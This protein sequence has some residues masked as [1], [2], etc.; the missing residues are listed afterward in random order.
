M[1]A[2]SKRRRSGAQ[3]QKGERKVEDI[4]KSARTVLTEDGY[5]GFTMRKIASTAGMAIGNLHY[6]YKNKDDI[7]HDLLDNTIKVYETTFDHIL[8]DGIKTDAEKF[9]EIISRIVVD[10]GTKQ[11]TRFFPE[12]WA[13]AN[14]DDCVAQGMAQLYQRARKYMRVLI[15]NLNPQ[16]NEDQCR[17]VSLFI[18]ASLEGQTIFVGYRKPWSGAR[19][20]VADFAA[21]KFTEMV[22]NLRPE[23]F[24]A[25]EFRDLL[26]S[27]SPYF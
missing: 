17:L 10:L 3:S 11:T 13:L 20:L 6:Y 1:T 26:P 27:V 16:L 12:L 2:K 9:S 7:L 18:S 21:S 23:D 19:K 15:K 22:I 5:Q 4:L 25:K 24:N 14:H 8:N